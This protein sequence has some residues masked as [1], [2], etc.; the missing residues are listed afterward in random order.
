MNKMHKRLAA[1]LLAASMAF[2]AALP[3]ESAEAKAKASAKAPTVSTKKVT[4]QVKSS[5]TVK[6][7]K[8][9]YPNSQ[10]LHGHLYHKVR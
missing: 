6:V 10:R 2:P 3:A 9:I 5:K 7:K 4:V 8:N 1:C